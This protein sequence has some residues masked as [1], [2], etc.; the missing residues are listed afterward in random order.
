M[1]GLAF[2]PALAALVASFALLAPPTPFSYGPPTFVVDLRVAPPRPSHGAAV[3][4]RRERRRGVP[5]V[6]PVL[7]SIQPTLSPRL[8]AHN[9]V[10]GVDVGV[11][12]V[13]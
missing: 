5:V 2:H 12:G 4:V 11:G 13:F 3:V 10:E 1:F 9:D 7:F 6:A 8:S